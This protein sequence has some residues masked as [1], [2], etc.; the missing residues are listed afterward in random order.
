MRCIS[1]A[2]V[3][4]VLAPA[5]FGATEGGSI[6]VPLPLFPTNNWWNTDV[7]AAPLDANSSNF[8]TFIGTGK[9]LHPDFG[10][11][12]GDGTVYGFPFILVDGA[13][14]KK[15]VVFTTPE[16]SDGV[17]HTTQTSIPFYPVPDE[18]I[19][20]PGWIEEGQP[21]NIDARG[22]SDR[23][24][25]MVDTTNNTLYELYSVFYNGT[26][27][28]AGSGAFFDM[29]TNNRRPETWTSAD[30]AG[31]AILPGLLR[32]DEVFGP[33][34]I[35]HAIRFTVFRSNGY[36]YPASHSAGST[37]GA[38]PMGARLRLKA[39]TNITG[40][41][42]EIQ[43]IFRAF[44]KYG[45]IV[46]DNGS[47]MYISGTYDTRWDNGVLNPAFGALKVSDFEVVQ[48]GWQ[49]SFSFVITLPAAMG[50]GDAATATVTAYDANYNVATG[51][52]GTVHFTATDGAPT[53]PVD[54]TFTS[55]DAGVHTFTN[56][57][58]LRTP[59]TQTVTLADVAD[60]TIKGFRIVAVGPST[61]T[62]L[63]ATATTA[64]HVDVSWTASAGA[65]QYEV[66]RASASVGYTTL[67][68]TAATSYPDTTALAGNTYVYKVRAIDASSRLSPFSV[69]DAAT[70]IFFSDDPL[71]ATTS[72]V[73]A[74]HITDL[75]QAVN[76]MRAA[77]QLTPTLFTDS[78]L[79]TINAVHVQE[80]RTAL[81]AA[82]TALGLAPLTFTDSTLTA[83][84]T[85]VRAVHVQ[86]LRD[87]VK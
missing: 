20:M 45:L 18:A 8:L 62:G 1:I 70:T 75:R 32:Y 59:G 17:D 41:T 36:V 27:W 28:V 25:L 67:T 74:A 3:L 30:A 4:L 53:L 81:A 78:T 57:V 40:F 15:T 82:R 14:A 23:H 2:A 55:G 12:V 73:K 38:L 22:T 49:P 56:G 10:G 47:D 37:A 69:P 76:A 54:Y 66:Q 52:R 44:K 42:P 6:P 46:A 5:A 43:K 21:G 35:N 64:T 86:Q 19:T 72:I 77:A 34:E 11:N 29:N 85:T 71:L 58:T 84:T 68:M 61:P 31:L 13:Q 50:A 83:G 33:N 87:G 60:A 48:Q 16:E 24:M 9:G 65:T 79:T 26:S 51:Y 39:S 80:L 7:S 63:T